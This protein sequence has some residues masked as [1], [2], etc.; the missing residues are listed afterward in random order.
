VN[1]GTEILPDGR[2]ERLP[3]PRESRP[4]EVYG[5]GYNPHGYRYRARIESKDTWRGKRFRFVGEQKFMGWRD[6]GPGF[7]G[8]QSRWFK[9]IG[10]AEAAANRW[11]DEKAHDPRKTAERYV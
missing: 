4:R 6:S 10:I 9:T 8:R 1:V 7:S 11:L 2:N 5:G 3:S